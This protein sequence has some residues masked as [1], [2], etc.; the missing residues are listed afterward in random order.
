MIP[1]VSDRK[2]DRQ[3]EGVDRL[4]KERE[5]E[6]KRVMLELNF[7]KVQTRLLFTNADKINAPETKI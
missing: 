4:Y 6:K 2:R 3:K 5:R 1:Y 7:R